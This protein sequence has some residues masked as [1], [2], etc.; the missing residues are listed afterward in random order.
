MSDQWPGGDEWTDE[1]HEAYLRTQQRAVLRGAVITGLAVGLVTAALT[2]LLGGT[3]GWLVG[4]VAGALS[5]VASFLYLRSK[6][7]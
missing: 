1:E 4:L 6:V 5:G 7:G 3:G 2:G